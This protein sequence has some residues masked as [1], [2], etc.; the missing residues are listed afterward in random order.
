MPLRTQPPPSA[1]SQLEYANT[2]TTG[3]GNDIVFSG[4][5]IDTI[6]TGA[7][8]DRIHINGGADTVTA[9]AGADTLIVDFSSAT[10]AIT[11]SAPTG[12][13]AAGYTGNI[14]GAEIVTYSGIEAFD[15]TSGVFDDVI[16]TGD[17]ADVVRSG[18]G[19]DTVSLGGGDDEA[20]YSMAAN[21]GASD[22]YQGGAGVDTLTL[23]LAEAEWLSTEVQD[24][25]AAFLQFVTDN[26]DDA[27]GFWSS[28]TFQFEAFNL[29]ASGFGKLNVTVDGVALDL[30]NDMAPVITSVATVTIDE[31]STA[32]VQVTASDVDTVG[33]LSYA[34]L[35]GE[36][37]ALFTID[38]VTGELSF[39]D[40]PDFEAFADTGGDNV[41]DVTV[42]GSDGI[43]T[44]TQAI[45]VTVTDVDE[46]NNDYIFVGDGSDII[47][48]DVDGDGDLDG[49]L[50]TEP[51][52]IYTEDPEDPPGWGSSE[53]VDGPITLLINNGG[54]Q[55]G[56][57]GAFT[58]TTIGTT[59]GYNRVM[60][61][62]G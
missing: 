26:T 30:I 56:I 38:A 49:I 16:K 60:R 36:D 24:D 18:A 9:G 5:G 10:G 4:L 45:A 46:V 22:V 12:T 25:I 51:S 57:E 48:G 28:D 8:D 11:M 33:T 37:A 44:D 29:T 15:I 27:T 23:E 2:V 40:A 21:T 52:Y 6:T 54:V 35:P 3:V 62:F 17:G 61:E 20:I 13:L 55:G 34:L 59:D 32:V 7:G 50:V 58:S 42:Q 53:R 1:T 19:S 41:Y 14:A 47:L 39:I 31:N 43:Q